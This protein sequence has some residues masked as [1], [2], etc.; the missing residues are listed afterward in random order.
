MNIAG[1][2]SESVEQKALFQWWAYAH[3][4]FNLPEKALF[5]IP[6]GGARTAQTG[7]RLKAEGVRAGVPDVFLAVP[8]GDAHGLFL[9]LKRAKGGRTSRAQTET[10]KIFDLLGYRCV[11]ARGAREAIDCVTEYLEGRRR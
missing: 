9:E 10:M 2:K 1:H 6:N 11:V 5:A 7:A 4:G 8:S 3:R